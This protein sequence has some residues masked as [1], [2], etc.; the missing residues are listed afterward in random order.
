MQRRNF[1]SVKDESADDIFQSADYFQ[2][3]VKTA[4]TDVV[5]QSREIMPLPWTDMNDTLGTL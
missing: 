5:E 4:A 3:A 1:S 2:E